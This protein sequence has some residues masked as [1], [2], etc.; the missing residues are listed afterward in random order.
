MLRHVVLSVECKG[1]GSV[2]ACIGEER[3]AHYHLNEVKC[4]IVMMMMI[5]MMMNIL[6]TVFI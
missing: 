3:A 5:L 6:D 2:T 4:R 1:T